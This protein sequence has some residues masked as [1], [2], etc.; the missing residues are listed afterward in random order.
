MRKL[1]SYLGILLLVFNGGCA[2]LAAEGTVGTTD[3]S[4][5]FDALHEKERLQQE[6]ESK[7]QNQK[8][9]E[10][11]KAMEEFLKNDLTT[12][13]PLGIKAR[14]I[15]K[16]LA[17][18]AAVK[19]YQQTSA[20]EPIIAGND[21]VLFPYGLSPSKLA[22]AFLTT[23]SIELQENEHIQSMHPGDSQRWWFGETVTGSGESL[24]P[25]VIVKPLVKEEIS[26]N[27]LISTDRRVYTI[28]LQS[29]MEGAY[30]PRIGFFY[31]Q[32]PQT[33]K[34]HGA[35]QDSFNQ[36]VVDENKVDMSLKEIAQWNFLYKVKGS[37]DVSF[38]P[39]QVFDNGKKLFIQMPDGIQFKDI[40][41]FFAVG[42]GGVREVVNYRFKDGVYVID[43]LV[44]T[45]VLLLNTNGKEEKVTITKL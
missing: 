24:K 18:T 7:Q 20:V 4:P 30:T 15:N 5:S 16:D 45:G 17:I 19:R 40:P 6:A 31:P 13:E 11:K 12:V 21:L 43:G 42:P 36:S 22:C 2:A 3:I 29:V 33:I 23:C 41:V 10:E 44:K 26:T 35:P 38:Y 34:T 37:K 28:Q 1:F 9:V 25:V 14:P 27:L 32:E 39:K 8:A